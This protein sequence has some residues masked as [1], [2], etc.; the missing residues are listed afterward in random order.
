MQ[1]SS[2]T[3]AQPLALALE[4]SKLTAGLELEVN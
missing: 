1:I 3:V 2:L 4:A